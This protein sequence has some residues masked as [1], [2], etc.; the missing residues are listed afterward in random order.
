M[1]SNMAKASKLQAAIKLL[2]EADMLVQQALGASD[3]CYE[4]HC[5]LENLQETLEGFAEQL[6]EMQITE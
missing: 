5:E 3:E 1:M 2:N 6:E 4:V